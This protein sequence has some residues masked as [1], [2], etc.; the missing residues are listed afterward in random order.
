MPDKLPTR[1]AH[2]HVGKPSP[3]TVNPP[4]LRGSTVLFNTV[5]E[6]YDRSST[7][8]GRMGLGVQRELE[9]GMRALEGAEHA[10]LTAN[11]M[12]ACALAIAA[13][14]DAGDHILVSSS[15]YG[16]TRHFC[17]TRLKAMG[18][19]TRFFDPLIGKDIE[20]LLQECD[21]QP[22]HTRYKLAH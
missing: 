5:D 4:V 16:P 14:V 3:L 20:E 18:V 8:Y 21:R 7:N 10:R 6:L 19:E 1:L 13:A 2:L 22:Q 11:G 9:A 15:A 17:E 12:Q